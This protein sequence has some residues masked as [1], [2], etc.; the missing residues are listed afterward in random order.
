M[1][2]RLSTTLA[3]LLDPPS[4]D[5]DDLTDA[6]EGLFAPHEVDVPILDHEEGGDSDSE[7]E[8]F[9][10]QRLPEGNL[11]ELLQ[12]ERPVQIEVAQDDQRRPDVIRNRQ[13]RCINSIASALDRSNYNPF[14]IPMARKE[15]TASV[16][17]KDLGPIWI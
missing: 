1:S 15:Y 4:E 11:Q 8:V 6:N 12:E 7:D 14:E 13:K 17:M 9:P 2:Q 16:K 10:A 5:E 3:A